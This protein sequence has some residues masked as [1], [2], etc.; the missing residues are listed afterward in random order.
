MKKRNCVIIAIIFLRYKFILRRVS[1]TKAIFLRYRVRF[2]SNYIFSR[3]T[4]SDSMSQY[5]FRSL[6]GST[7]TKKDS[8]IKSMPVFIRVLQFIEKATSFI[9]YVLFS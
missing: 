9:I 1:I 7:T 5:V 2:H 8:T 4:P 6:T 3:P